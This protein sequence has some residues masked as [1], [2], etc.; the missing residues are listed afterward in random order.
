[1]KLQGADVYC[2]VP[3]RKLLVAVGSM[4]DEWLANLEMIKA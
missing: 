4:P 3:T 1:M 2:H